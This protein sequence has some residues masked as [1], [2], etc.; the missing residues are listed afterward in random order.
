MARPRYPESVHLNAPRNLLTKL[1][2]LKLVNKLL[3]LLD[4]YYGF[5]RS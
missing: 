3:Y 4:F 5:G 2:I 1:Y